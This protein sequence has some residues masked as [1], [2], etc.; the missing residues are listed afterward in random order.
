[1]AMATGYQV[2]AAVIWYII[3]TFC[4]VRDEDSRSINPSKTVLSLNISIR[5][6][7]VDFLVYSAPGKKYDDILTNC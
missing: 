3:L 2:S 5:A 6:I 4:H 7:P 1:M